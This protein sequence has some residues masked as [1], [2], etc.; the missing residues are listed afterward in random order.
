MQRVLGA[1]EKKQIVLP[2]V[3]EQAAEEFL[4]RLTENKYAVFVDDNAMDYLSP[5]SKIKEKL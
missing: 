5:P 1:I 3:Q 4:Q 2:T